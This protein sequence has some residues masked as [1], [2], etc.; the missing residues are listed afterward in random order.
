M[1]QSD[2]EAVVCLLQPVK[3]P[4]R[5]TRFVRAYAANAPCGKDSLFELRDS[6]MAE[7][8]LINDDT[9]TCPDKD[10]N[11]VLTI[12]NHSLMPVHLEEGLVLGELHQLDIVPEDR[13]KKLSVE[14]VWDEVQAVRPIPHC[15]PV[16]NPPT[17]RPT[18]VAKEHGDQ[19]LDALDVDHE[20]LSSKE[21]AA[22]QALVS[23][24]AD[25]FALDPS[26]FRGH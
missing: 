10:G 4:A 26:E 25:V 15:T 8:G 14:L 17:P 1:F 24:Y 22:L 23:E 5:H 7:K 18:H 20:T 6:L 9:A 3:V 19:V 16:D 21:E 12:Q 11:V 13:A 2:Q